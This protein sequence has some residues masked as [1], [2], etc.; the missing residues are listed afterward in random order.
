MRSQIQKRTFP[1]S[2]EDTYKL[3]ADVKSYPEFLPWCMGAHIHKETPE[4]MVADLTIGYGLFND[5]FTSHVKLQPYDSIHV[6]CVK[7]AVDN[8]QNSWEFRAINDNETEVTFSLDY[9]F[10]N[11]FLQMAMDKIYD[12]AFAKMTDAFLERARVVYG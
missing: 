9:K 3:V 11:P 12:T 10:K 2:I 6:N 4:E 8:L 7:G 5:S 1:Y